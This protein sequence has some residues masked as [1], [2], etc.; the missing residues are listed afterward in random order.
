MKKVYTFILSVLVGAAVMAADGRPRSGMINI[1]INDNSAVRVVVDGR[2]Y[3][4]DHNVSISNLSTGYHTVQVFRE[5]TG[6]SIFDRFGRNREQLLWSSSL[7]VKAGTETDVTINQNGRAKVREVNMPYST[8][9][10]NGSW[11]NSNDRDDHSRADDHSRNDGGYNNGGYDNGSY[12][13][14]SSHNNN[15]GYNNNNS[16][17]YRK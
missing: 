12:G 2:S 15:G 13:N 11:G 9:Y 3:N 16:N 7:N 5:S 8:G 1:S 17:G 6:R 14:N 4:N 10:N